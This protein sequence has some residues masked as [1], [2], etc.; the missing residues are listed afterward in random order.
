MNIDYQ[1]FL[2][3]DGPWEVYGVYPDGD[4]R[5]LWKK[6]MLIVLSEQ[7]GED[8][9]RHLMQEYDLERYV[10]SEK[11]I[12]IFPQCR[13]GHWTASEDE[14]LSPDEQLLHALLMQAGGSPG[15]WGATYDVHHLL[16]IDSGADVVCNLVAKMPSMGCAASVCAIGGKTQMTAKGIVES[17]VPALLVDMPQAAVDY[18][19]RVNQVDAQD[20]E[21][22]YCSHNP[23]QSVIVT[24]RETFQPATLWPEFSGKVRRINSSAAGDVVARSYRLPEDAIIRTDVVLSDGLSHDWVEVLP[25][26]VKAGKSDPVPLMLISH[27]MGDCPVMAAEQFGMHLIG[28]REGFITVYVYSS[29]HRG[30]NLNLFPDQ[31]DD[32]KYYLALID[33]LRERYPIDTTR[34]YTT[35]FSNGAGMAMLFALMHPEIVAASCPVDSTFP[36]ATMKFFNPARSAPYLTR[37]NNQPL[38]GPMPTMDPD[39]ALAPLRRALAQQQA[40]ETPLRMPVMYFYGSRENE[41][42]IRAGSNQELNYRFWKDFNGIPQGETDDTLG[43]TDAVGVPGMQIN[44]LQPYAAHPE[45]TFSDHVFFTDEGLDAYHLVLMH[46]KAHDVHPYEAELGWQY[47]SRFSRNPDGSLN[48]TKKG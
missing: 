38:G 35:G 40:R 10:N 11:M 43:G 44:V 2:S 37:E 31:P 18:F 19:C 17:A 24:T 41:Y 26:S 21:R 20:G 15:G 48:D 5:C 33:F 46:G 1:R 36:Y 42:P 39:T 23:A 30:W 29:N 25:P 6:S 34:I 16:G 9:V 14:A 32:V 45:H 13:D 12:V 22:R 4:P 7:T 27:G 47:V 28:E 3:P 8:A